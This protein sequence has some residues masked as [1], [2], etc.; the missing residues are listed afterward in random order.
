MGI[1]LNLMVSINAV[2]G[3]NEV[4]KCNTIKHVYVLAALESAHCR[5]KT[6]SFVL[7][8]HPLRI[9]KSTLANQFTFTSL[10]SLKLD[11]THL[12]HPVL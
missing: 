4:G 8:Q 3:K 9:L 1:L 7:S 2:W 12:A 10:S 5:T 6:I 11:V